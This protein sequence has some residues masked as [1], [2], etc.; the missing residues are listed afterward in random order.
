MG[1]A[2][3][4]SSCVVSSFCFGSMYVAVRKSGDPRDGMVVQWVVCSAIFLV[5]FLT[6]LFTGC[7]PFQHFAMF[8]G[9]L[10]ALGNLTAVPIINAIGLG[11]GILIWGVCGC[12]V[13]WAIG[14]F[15]LFGVNP[16]VP[17]SP[18]LNYA[19]LVFVIIGGILFAL[20]RPKDNKNNAKNDDE[21]PNELI[22]QK[23][24]TESGAMTEERIGLVETDKGG[25]GTQRM[26]ADGTDEGNGQRKSAEK[27]ATENVAKCMDSN[28]Q[29]RIFAIC[30]AVF[31]G[32]CYGAM[33]TP[34]IYMQDNSELF[35]NPPKDAILYVFSHFSGV[36][37]TSTAVL[38]IYICFT[39]NRPY[40][41]NRLIFP[42]LLA[43]V[44]WAIAMLAWFVAND[45]LSQ[46]I[47]FPI[48]SMAP[49]VIASVWSVLYFKEV[50][51]R[52]LK[53]LA[54]AML[55]TIFG[56]VLVGLSK[57]I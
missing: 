17:N 2:L 51:K 40:M 5:G 41:D 25:D 32:I 47:T 4:L 44:F 31:A 43:G 8:G 36:Y 35:D 55:V 27:L 3:G 48:N 7:P 11:M 1:V 46:A 37:L 49:G 12:V 13:G 29:K 57:A 34:V 22:G 54:S 33:F 16:N 18:I 21:M 10:W 19:G 56:A 14:R 38:L 20:V 15:G 24:M 42:A 6:F 30:S 9:A 28:L 50:D 39:K 26:A 45:Q 53:L 52:D 23:T